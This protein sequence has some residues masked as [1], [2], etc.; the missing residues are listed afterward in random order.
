MK[1]VQIFLPL[2]DNRGKRFGRALFGQVR[3][4]LVGR[5]G[6]LTAYSR[7]PA[8]GLWR[9]PR[10]TQSDDIV[11]F[12]VMAPRLNVGWWRTYRRRLEQ[13]FRQEKLLVL[14]QDVR[15]V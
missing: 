13:R 8:R 15:S 3:R 9:S 7:A 2:R 1:L 11:I 14:V 12:E 5:Y 10:G 4:E 6:G